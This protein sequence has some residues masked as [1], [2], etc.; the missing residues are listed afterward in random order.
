[1]NQKYIANTIVMVRPSYFCFNAETSVSNAFQN[2]P[3]FENSV[4]Q[5]TVMAEFNLM[6]EKIGTNGINV[7][8]LMEVVLAES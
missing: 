4:L 1:M 8:I 3:S 6:V 7:I 5:E 2:K